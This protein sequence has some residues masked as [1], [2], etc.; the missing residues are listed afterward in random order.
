MHKS[1]VLPRELDPSWCHP[2]VNPWQNENSSFAHSINE[3]SFEKIK[4]TNKALLPTTIRKKRGSLTVSKILTNNN[5][6]RLYNTI[7]VV[8]KKIECYLPV[9]FEESVSSGCLL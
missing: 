5:N 2:L 1:S 6:I 3:Q 8:E 9:M 4:F 7:D